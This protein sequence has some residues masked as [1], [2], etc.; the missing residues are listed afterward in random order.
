MVLP[1][2]FLGKRLS[3][4]FFKSHLL[5]H[6]SFDPREVSVEKV[7]FAGDEDKVVASLEQNDSSSSTPQDSLMS[8]MRFDGGGIKVTAGLVN[9][10]YDTN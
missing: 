8:S 6:K 3:V 9:A 10:T 7:A 1:S 2:S 5:L 4:H